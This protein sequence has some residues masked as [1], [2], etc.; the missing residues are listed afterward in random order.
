MDQLPQT[1]QTPTLPQPMRRDHKLLGSYNKNSKPAKPF[2]SLLTDTKS[3]RVQKKMTGEKSSN[4]Q[5]QN[6][7]LLTQN[8][9]LRKLSHGLKSW[10]HQIRSLKG[11]IQNFPALAF[12][13]GKAPA[14]NSEEFV[15]ILTKNEFISSGLSSDLK[16][17][18]HKKMKFKDLVEAFNLGATVPKSSGLVDSDDLITPTQFFK[19]L[20]IDPGRVV[21]EISR[22]KDVLPREGISPYLVKGQQKHSNRSNKQK[23]TQSPSISDKNPLN[24]GKYID[25]KPTKHM[26][27]KSR[28]SHSSPK[29]QNIVSD[30]VDVFTNQAAK[31]NSLEKIKLNLNS[32]QFD[33]P[34]TNSS[35][36]LSYV[37]DDNSAIANLKDQMA[38][39][40][41]RPQTR[42][43]ASI[44]K[45]KD[46]STPKV[47][48]SSSFAPTTQA[49]RLKPLAPEEQIGALNS[50]NISHKEKQTN[51]SAN[52]PIFK[53]EKPLT[54]DSS[55]LLAN[56]EEI[57]PPKGST[58]PEKNTFSGNSLKL[59][60]QKELN[61]AS[62]PKIKASPEDKYLFVSEKSP[63]PNK[64]PISIAEKPGQLSME[65]NPFVQNSNST[66][67]KLTSENGLSGKTNLNVHSK[68]QVT[69]GNSLAMLQESKEGKEGKES[70][71]N[72]I[73]YSKT[74]AELSAN[75]AA[76][77]VQIK[78]RFNVTRGNKRKIKI[79]DKIKVKIKPESI[80]SY[81]KQGEI[82]SHIVDNVQENMAKASAN[83]NTP[84]EGEYLA[85]NSPDSP[86]ATEKADFSTSSN[87]ERFEL[88]NKII[89]QSMASQ[90]LG[91]GEADLLIQ[92]NIF[93]E[94][95]MKILVEG[96]DVTL[97]M[98]NPS[99][100]VKNL[101]G[102]DINLLKESLST[103]D[104][105]LVDVDLDYPSSGSNL[106]SNHESQLNEHGFNSENR[107]ENHSL[108]ADL[109]EVKFNR[110]IFDP[111]SNSISNHHINVRV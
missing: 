44:E 106:A 111:R 56:S 98:L 73:F 10:G 69:D 21:A 47:L 60:D 23:R 71:D 92:D 90:N 3:E 55:G 97:K 50:N 1:Q 15:N 36:K 84:S 45:T 52:N 53:T 67:S 91:G 9:A 25:P 4:F 28:K 32:E 58:I 8:P 85:T 48:S 5:K 27:K 29:S 105:N 86:V 74:D 35:P 18:M 22:L 66:T 46:K 57:I 13:S 2:Q 31:L 41:A 62:I 110:N 88:I 54:L 80:P 59:S 78:P 102:Q 6:E 34:D 89:E 39:I 100:D 65:N 64:T 87:L 104:L 108:L 61:S 95:S 19:A 51:Q 70:Q 38:F 14:E 12:L 7:A 11:G 68:P 96:N 81:R 30:P 94:I 37:R 42:P 72:A 109:P 77:S 43:A 107:E 26:G 76:A 16:V 24:T 17:L 83:Q 20:G 75:Q 103:Q 40:E 33:I 49:I 93:G 63:S 82:N 99:D 101:I 79:E